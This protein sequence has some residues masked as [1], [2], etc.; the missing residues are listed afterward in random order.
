MDT[1]DGPTYRL[2]WAVYLTVLVGAVALAAFLPRHPT[3]AAVAMA[4]IFAGSGLL[5]PP[6]TALGLRGVARPLTRPP[7]YAGLSLLPL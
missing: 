6:G 4:V 5:A 2:A 1:G 7:L 3:G